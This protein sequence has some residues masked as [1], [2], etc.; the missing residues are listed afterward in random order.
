MIQNDTNH[1]YQLNIHLNEDDLIGRWMS[2]TR[3][4]VKYE[5]YEKEHIMKPEYWGG[6]T[7][8]NLIRRKKYDLS[9]NMIDDEYVVENHAIMMYAPFLENK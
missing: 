1:V 3:A 2:N 7:R 6:Y 9:D 5:V 4:E 8:H